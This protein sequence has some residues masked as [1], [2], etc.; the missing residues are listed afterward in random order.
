MKK[1][2]NALFFV[3][4]AA[5][6]GTGLIAG[7]AMAEEDKITQKDGVTVYTPGSRA[8]KAVIDEENARPMPLPQATIKP[9]DATVKS[10]PPKGEPGV[11]AGSEGDDAKD[12]A[13]TGTTKVQK[14]Q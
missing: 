4:A 13:E 8:G 14:K 6:F 10:A 2:S 3:L 12:T 9:G 5:V 7:C 11:A 1:V